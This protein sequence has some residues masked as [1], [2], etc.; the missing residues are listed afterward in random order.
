MCPHCQDFKPIY[1]EVAKQLQ[2]DPDGSYILGE[3]NTMVQERLGKHF[4]IRGLP[5]VLIFSPNNEYNPVTFNKNRTVFDL[6]TEIELVSGL[7]SRE[8]KDYK[9]LTERISRRNEN[10]LVGIF[11]DDKLPLYTEMQNLKNDFNFVRIY[12]SFNIED[13]RKAMGIQ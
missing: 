10:I 9:E 12:Y 6:V 13:F 3:V 7:M 5:T 1:V 2:D 8:L 4:Q 11:K